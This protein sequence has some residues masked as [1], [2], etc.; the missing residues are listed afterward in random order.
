MTNPRH[1]Q[2]A[3]CRPGRKQRL[4]ERK[5]AGHGIR[6]KLLAATLPGPAKDISPPTWLRVRP[7]I[8]IAVRGMVLGRHVREF[9]S[10]RDGVYP[11][12]ALE[13]LGK[14]LKA[15]CADERA[16]DARQ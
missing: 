8:P 15:T 2:F 13:I 12:R 11:V 7:G 14:M 4:G 5:G 9:S 1:V 10:R 16:R 6:R 3:M